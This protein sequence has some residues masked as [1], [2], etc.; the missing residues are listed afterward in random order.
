M[1]GKQTPERPSLVRH[2]EEAPGKVLASGQR[3]QR[4]R[5]KRSGGRGA[6]RRERT[7]SGR[8]WETCPHWFSLLCDES[9]TLDK[10]SI[11]LSAKCATA[12][13]EVSPVSPHPD[14]LP[15]G[16]GTASRRFS[17]CRKSTGNRRAP[18]CRALRT[19]LPLPKGEGR[20]EE[21]ANVRTPPPTAP[22]RRCS[23][24]RDSVVRSDT[25]ASLLE[26][27]E[28]AVVAVR[29]KQDLP[30]AIRQARGRIRNTKPRRG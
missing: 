12:R 2:V 27:I 3:E 11:R 5:G 25:V 30:L 13:A 26:V 29:R 18:I 23:R 15:R 21:E 8:F 20:G 9:S 10:P 14:P 4:R 24:S 6:G 17:I 22:L 19:V 7:R 28:A 1:R 16:E